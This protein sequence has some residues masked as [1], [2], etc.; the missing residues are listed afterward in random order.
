[1]TWVKQPKYATLGF[2]TISHTV[3]VIRIQVE[4]RICHVE[5]ASME[6]EFNAEIQTNDWRGGLGVWAI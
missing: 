3:C 6:T 5:L 1:M 4:V 2:Q